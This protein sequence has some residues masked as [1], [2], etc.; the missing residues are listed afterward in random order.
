MKAFGPVNGSAWAIYKAGSGGTVPEDDLS[1]EAGEY[2][3][4][5]VS[6]CVRLQDGRIVSQQ[7]DGWLELRPA[8]DPGPWELVAV[9]GHAITYLANGRA[10]VYVATECPK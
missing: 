5:E 6:D 10:F 9:D 8:G 4:V 7:P 3:P 1:F 2:L